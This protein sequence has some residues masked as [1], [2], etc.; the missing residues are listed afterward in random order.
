MGIEEPNSAIG[1]LE[2]VGSHL[3]HFVAI[4]LLNVIA[5]FEALLPSISLVLTMCEQVGIGRQALVVVIN[6][7][8]W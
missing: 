6:F 7:L 1:V 8:L 3:E 2:K 5:V 4:Y